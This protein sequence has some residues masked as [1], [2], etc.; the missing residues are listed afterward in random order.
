MATHR[1]YFSAPP[2][3][4][5][6]WQRYWTDPGYQ[7]RHSTAPGAAE[8]RAAVDL[9]RALTLIE[10]RVAVVGNGGQRELAALH[11]WI[12]TFAAEAVA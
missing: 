1:D 4:P 7:A 8:Q 6:P 11:G 12:S 10:Q 3:Q 9:D 2:T 5:Q